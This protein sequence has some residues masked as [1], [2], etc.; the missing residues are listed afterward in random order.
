LVGHIY[1]I[2]DLV[3]PVPLAHTASWEAD[4]AVSA[5]MG[6]IETL[7]YS[8]VPRCI[9][10][11]PEAAFVGLSEEQARKAGHTP[12]VDRFHFAGNSKALIEDES[13]GFW[14][15]ISEATSQKL[16]G[17]LLVGPHATELIHLVALAIKAGLAASDISGTIFAHPSLAESFREVAI[18]TLAAKKTQARPDAGRGSP[19]AARL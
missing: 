19:P 15:S 6:E 8:A 10:T 7:D 3:S 11:W 18:R 13:E 5:M 9:Y 12:R 14:V 2:G 4:I 16:L 17:G 1:A